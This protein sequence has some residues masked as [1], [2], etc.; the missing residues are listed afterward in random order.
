MPSHQKAPTTVLVSLAAFGDRELVHLVTENALRFL[1]PWRLALHVSPPGYGH[2]PLPASWRP[3]VLLNPESRFVR[4]HGPQVLGIHLSNIAL[5]AATHARSAS[6]V[7]LLPGNAILVR[8]CG[9]LLASAAASFAGDKFSEIDWPEHAIRSRNL[10]NVSA[11]ASVYRTAGAAP[12]SPEWEESRQRVHARNDT[13][14]RGDFYF[15]V[16]TRWTGAF[17]EARRAGLRATPIA[18]TQ[19]EGA[20]PASTLVQ[21]VAVRGRRLLVPA[22]GEL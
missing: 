13:S 16:W 20:S 14:T 22:V 5:F 3:T 8:P 4:R 17:S 21:C 19:H 7:V 11:R 18:N 1:Q 15:F 2:L 10:G 6:S 12:P 9:R